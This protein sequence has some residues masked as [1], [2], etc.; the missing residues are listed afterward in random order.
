M[1]IAKN[2][3]EFTFKS[4]NATIEAM[5]SEE[6]QQL[7]DELRLKSLEKNPNLTEDEWLKIKQDFLAFMYFNL[8]R[9]NEDLMKEL[10]EHLYTEL[11]KDEN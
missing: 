9:D 11:N 1:K 10:G 4:I 2:L 5:N 8:I 3:D 6:G 7:V